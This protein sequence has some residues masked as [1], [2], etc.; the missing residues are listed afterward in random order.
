MR[1]SA[2][3]MRLWHIQIDQRSRARSSVSNETLPALETYG[4]KAKV[5]IWIQIRGLNLQGEVR[6]L[7]IRGCA[8]LASGSAHALARVDRRLRAIAL[9]AIVRG[10][11]ADK[12]A[13]AA[14]Q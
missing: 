12:C 11:H 3:A 1:S 8:P 9:R 6:G 4:T 10:T 2:K 7:E 14:S 13:V 5:S